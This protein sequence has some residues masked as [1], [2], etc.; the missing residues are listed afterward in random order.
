MVE[1]S[2]REVERSDREVEPS[3]VSVHTGKP[4]EPANLAAGS[5]SALEIR[6]VREPPVHLLLG[7]LGALH[8]LLNLGLLALFVIALRRKFRLG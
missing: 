3:F 5:S 7:L 2:D 4:I 6:C 1:R 8:G